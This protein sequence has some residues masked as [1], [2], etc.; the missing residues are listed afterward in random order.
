MSIYVN[1]YG[2]T[3]RYCIRF[4]PLQNSDTN[5]YQS[6]VDLKYLKKV[7]N[8]LFTDRQRFNLYPYKMSIIDNYIINNHFYYSFNQYY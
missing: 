4:F 2:N 8:K 5:D 6:A 3:D 7:M 1:A